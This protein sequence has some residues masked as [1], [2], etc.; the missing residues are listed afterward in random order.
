MRDLTRRLPIDV[1]LSNHSGW[2]GSLVKMKALAAAGPGGS[3]PFVTGPQVVDRS[4]QVMGECA[5]A[6]SDRFRM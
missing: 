6:Q 3:N 2:D 4:L 5:R 1:L